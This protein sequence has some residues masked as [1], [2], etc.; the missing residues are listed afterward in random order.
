MRSR[1]MGSSSF[2]VDATTQYYSQVRKT[3]SYYQLASLDLLDK[4]RYGA[5]FLCIESTFIFTTLVEE[6]E[7]IPTLS[8]AQAKEDSNAIIRELSVLT[9]DSNAKPAGAIPRLTRVYAYGEFSRLGITREE[10]MNTIKKVGYILM[11]E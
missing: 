3:F 11:E 4:I 10:L 7:P 8:L 2:S 9:S 1:V 5:H 6:G